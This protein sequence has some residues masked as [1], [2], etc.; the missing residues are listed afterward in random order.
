MIPV[1][2]QI[3]ISITTKDRW[4]DLEI[5]LNH[6]KAEGLDSL[7]T[8]VVDDGSRVALPAR[9]KEQFPWIKFMRFE[10]SQGLLP[11]RNRIAQLLSTP[12]ILGLDDDS[13]PIAGNL[14][15]AASWLTEHPKVC[16]LAFRID[17]AGEISLSNSEAGAPYPVKSFVGCANLIKRELFLALGGYEERLGYSAEE[18][19]FCLKAI[20]RGYETY[21]FPTVVIRHRVAQVARNLSRQSRQIVRNYM[22]VCL[23]HYPFPV[24]WLRALRYGP[25][26]IIK[27]AN[28]RKY[29]KDVVIGFFQGLA[30]YFSWPH[31]HKRLSRQQFQEWDK[32][33][34]GG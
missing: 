7:E 9:F 29:W 15:A 4:E 31:A 21:A 24:S 34:L 14:E 19:E 30:C 26:V 6:L 3:G 12:L 13:F 10:S 18:G 27:H 11:Q 20:K 22:L 8:I 32:L 5:T 25:V 17:Y 33:P 28:R 1:T 16:A 2:S 23:W